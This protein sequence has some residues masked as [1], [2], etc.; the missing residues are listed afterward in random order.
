MSDQSEHGGARRRYLA[1]L[2]S[3][4]SGSVRLTAAMEAEEFADCSR[5][6]VAPIKTK[7]A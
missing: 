2:F 7:P 1:I 5:A 4:L 3:D 6:F